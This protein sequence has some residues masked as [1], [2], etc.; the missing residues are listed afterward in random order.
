MLKIGGTIKAHLTLKNMSQKELANRLK[1]NHR[2]ISSYCNDVNYPD[3]ATLS[4]ICQIL[5]I[6]LNKVLHIDGTEEKE[7]YIQNDMEM[8]II[9][10]FRKVSKNKDQ[11]F[12]ESILK[13]A[14]L[15][16]D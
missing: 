2:T 11:E 7:F 15:C 16:E 6:D 9:Q 3:I 5:E 12:M 14:S 1:L 4:N 13:L 10:A 8:K